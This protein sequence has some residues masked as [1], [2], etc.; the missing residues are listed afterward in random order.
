MRTF[1][2]DAR[3][4]DDARG[5]VWAIGNFD[6]LHRGHG[7][8]FERAR[9][10]ARAQNALAGVL[11]FAPHPAKLLNPSLAPPLIL[12]DDEKERGIAAAGLDLLCVL[13]FD[14]RLA[15]L[16][17]QAFVQDVLHAR[18]G[19]AGA[20]V[21]EGFRFGHRAAGTV[22]DLRAGLAH[23]D[24]VAPVREG[25][26]VCSSS[27]IRELVLEGKTDAAAR[28][29][30]RPY[31]LEGEVVV[32]DRRG[33][34]I[35]IPTANLQTARELLPKL[36]VYA[37]SAVLADGRRFQSVTNIGLRPTF[38]GQSGVRIEAHLLAFSGDI[39]GQRLH[40]DVV[41]RLRDEMRFPGIDALKAQIAR[42]IDAA[43]GALDAAAAAGRA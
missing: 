17:P 5:A 25:D 36:G 13:R 34:T 40:L 29:L 26:L 9:A 10:T 1:R 15:A 19:A 12:T 32:G 31:W 42:D 30:G 24:V 43:V 18:L 22:D 4:P 2:D 6:G 20:V 41:A 35:G 14:A 16:S 39:Y 8:L 33:H 21:G 28:L 11:T 23:V 7:A 37:T 3:L 38:A 27:K